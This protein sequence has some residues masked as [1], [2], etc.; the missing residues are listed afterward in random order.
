[1]AQE[2]G[3]ALDFCLEETDSPD[4][5]RWHVLI[6]RRTATPHLPEP[7]HDLLTEAVAHDV[8]SGGCAVLR[9][10]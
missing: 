1:M 9:K 8:P 5:R 10:P 7:A 3:Q 4:G 6:N 2:P